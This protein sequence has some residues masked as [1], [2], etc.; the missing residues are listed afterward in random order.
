M[1][2]A[3][4]ETEGPTRNKSR[5][6]STKSILFYPATWTR[7]MDPR[8]LKDPTINVTTAIRL[9]VLTMISTTSSHS[10]I[11]EWCKSVDKMDKKRRGEVNC[12]P[13]K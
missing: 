12:Y 3:I 2:C 13:D 7:P 5:W 4:G 6:K 10:H 8:F 11:S 9:H 1:V